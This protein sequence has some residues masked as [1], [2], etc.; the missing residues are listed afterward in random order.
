MDTSGPRTQRS[1]KKVKLAEIVTGKFTIVGRRYLAESLRSSAYNPPL[2]LAWGSDTTAASVYDTKLVTEKERAQATIA[3]T[4]NYVN[5]T[6]TF[7]VTAATA[8]VAGEL[9]LFDASSGGI[10]Y[11][12]G[13]F[14]SAPTKAAGE[15]IIVDFTIYATQT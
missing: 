3:R 5:I 2:Y 11:W 13:R 4:T 9:G 14:T 15:T 7:T 10:M 6:K 8:G 1:W 12:T